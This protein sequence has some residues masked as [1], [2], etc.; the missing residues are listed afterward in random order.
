MGHWAYLDLRALPPGV[1][2]PEEDEEARVGLECKNA[3]PLFWLALLDESDLRGAWEAGL[4]AAF[5][6]PEG[7]TPVPP[8]VVGWPTAARRLRAAVARAPR[9]APALAGRLRAWAA[10]LEALAAR[11]PRVDRV[12][13]NVGEIGNSHD[14]PAPFLDELL[15]GVRLWHGAGAP[16]PPPDVRDPAQE[17]GGYTPDGAPFPPGVPDWTPGRPVPGADAP[18]RWWDSA[19]VSVPLGVLAVLGAGWVADLPGAAV[20]VAL[21]AGFEAWAAFRPRG[22]EPPR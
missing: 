8:L 11:C 10:A 12:E 13:L 15:R 22:P 16:P 20:A 17:L 14:D 3:P 9:R 21:Y 19:F 18:A 6:D 5:A 1:A 4:R 2:L 7:E